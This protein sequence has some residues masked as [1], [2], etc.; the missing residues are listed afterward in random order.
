MT[1]PQIKI[2]LK[3]KVGVG[4]FEKVFTVVIVGI[5]LLA[6]LLLFHYLIKKLFTKD[7][8][9]FSYMLDRNFIYGLGIIV[10]ILMWIWNDI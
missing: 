6:L 4:M 7:S 10:L 5:V 8:D 2:E 3:Y 1:S 9:S